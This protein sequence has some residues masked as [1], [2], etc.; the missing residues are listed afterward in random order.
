MSCAEQHG[1]R[2]D[3]VYQSESCG[4]QFLFSSNGEVWDSPTQHDSVFDLLRK[5][6]TVFMVD[7]KGVIE[8]DLLATFVFS[9][10]GW[11]SYMKACN[12]HRRTLPVWPWQHLVAARQLF[13]KHVSEAR[14]AEL[15]TKWGGIPRVVLEKVNIKSYQVHTMELAMG[16]AWKCANI[17]ATCGL[18]L[19]PDEDGDTILHYAVDQNFITTRVVFASQWAADL[20]VSFAVQQA[21]QQIRNRIRE[22]LAARDRHP[23]AA[24]LCA[25]LSEALARKA[26]QQ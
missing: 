8:H 19:N 6:T 13:F 25:Q 22:F 20:V 14:L 15:Y 21:E 16:S 4:Q 7:G 9:S 26:L 3:I 5:P 10:E 18:A 17:L 1:D 11:K 2:I 23:R 12:V 24:G